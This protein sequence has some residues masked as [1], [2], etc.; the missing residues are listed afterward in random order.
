MD[1]S[2]GTCVISVDDDLYCWGPNSSGRFIAA[3]DEWVSAPTLIP[4]AGKVQQVAVGGQLL[5]VLRTDGAVW[6]AGDPSALGS[7][8][9]GPDDTG[10]RQVALP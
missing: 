2:R 5:C 8:P 1:S 3:G 6:C 9:S 10:W 7:V 4:D